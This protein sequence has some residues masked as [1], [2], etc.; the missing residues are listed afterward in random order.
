MKTVAT[1]WS[2]NAKLTAT[3]VRTLGRGC[4]NLGAYFPPLQ[5][6]THCSFLDSSGVQ[7]CKSMV[8]LGGP[9]TQA[10]HLL[11]SNSIQ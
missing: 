9:P 10:Q 6:K 1:C 4:Q 3:I 7:R 5:S 2:R 8:P 11:V